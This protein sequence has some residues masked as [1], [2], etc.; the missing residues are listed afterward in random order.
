MKEI[1]SFYSNDRLNKGYSKNNNDASHSNYSQKSD[2][3][4]N[5][6]PIGLIEQYE[7]IHPGTLKAILSMAENEQKLRHVTEK[8]RISAFER[9]RRI[10]GVFGLT[11]AIIICYVSYSMFKTDP[12]A[13]LIFAFIAFGSLSFMTYLHYKNDREYLSRNDHFHNKRKFK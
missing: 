2:L 8:T 1:K 4:K 7:E 11:I 13:S 10:G 9:A 6:P 12:V 3:T 5:L